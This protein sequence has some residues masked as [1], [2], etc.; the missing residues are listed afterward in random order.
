MAIPATGSGLPLVLVF[1]WL[2]DIERDLTSV[3]DLHQ[4]RGLPFLRGLFGGLA[5]GLL[6]REASPQVLEQAQGLLKAVE[7]GWGSNDPSFRQG[8]VHRMF[9]DANSE[10][11]RAFDQVQ[12]NMISGVNATRFL[13]NGFHIGIQDLARQVRCPALVAQTKD[14]PL[15]PFSEGVLL[16]SLIPDSRFVPIYGSNHIPFKSDSARPLFL[17]E[18]RAFL[19]VVSSLRSIAANPAAKASVLTP[20]QRQILQAVTQGQTAKQIARTL[21]LSLRTVQIHVTRVLATLQCSSRAEAVLKAI[22]P[23]LL[24]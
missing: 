10:Q 11:L 17:A 14:D 19:S 24:A 9:R 7:I 1:N 6:V 8:F 4:F 16:A 3:D 15:L 21:N 20:R 13:K 2:T 18:L 22:K 12:R 5:R 23:G